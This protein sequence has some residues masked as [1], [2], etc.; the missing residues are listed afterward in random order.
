MEI[1][2]QYESIWRCIGAHRS[3]RGVLGCMGMHENKTYGCALEC[4][5]TLDG[6]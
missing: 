2:I 1:I 6:A 3:Y 5:G 4:V